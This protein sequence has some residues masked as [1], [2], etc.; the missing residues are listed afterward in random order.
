MT[1]DSVVAAVPPQFA[2]NNSNRPDSSADMSFGDGG[3]RVTLANG[4]VI[5][6]GS[7]ANLMRV[8][9]DDEDPDDFGYTQAKIE[10]KYGRLGGRLLT[11]CL[12]K[13]TQGLGISL[14]GDKDRAKAAVIVCGLNPHGNAH[15][16]G[17]MA[18]GDVILEVRW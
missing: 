6:A 12:N 5:D 18:V 7:A 1:A 9:G 2:N 10:R 4:L 13:G 14:A 17:R 15:R 16:D 3:A 11:V 8:A